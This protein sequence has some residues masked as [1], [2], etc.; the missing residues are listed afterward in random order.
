[1]SAKEK[2][3]VSGCPGC[4]NT[5]LARM[6]TLNLKHCTDCNRDIPWYVEDGQ[7]PIYGGTVDK[8][9]RK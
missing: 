6:G 2:T 7:A 9:R 8:E 1:M 5:E 4:G 3:E